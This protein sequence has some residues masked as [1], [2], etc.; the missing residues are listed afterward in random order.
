MSDPNPIPGLPNYRH[1]ALGD[2]LSTN[3]EG[4]DR[5]RSGEPGNLWVTG[6]RQLQGK[7]RR[8]RSW[9]S[10]KGN[11]YASLLLSGRFP[12]ARF[13]TLPLVA[14]LAVHDALSPFFAD[15]PV[16]PAIKWP[17]D[18]RVGGAKICGI[19]LESE[20]LPN[21]NMAVVIGCGINCAHFPDIDGYPA[22]SLEDCGVLIKPQDLFPYLAKAFDQVLTL[23]DRGNGF[24]TVRRR[25]LD[26]AEGVGKP[27]TVNLDNERISGTFDDIDEEG[28]L[29]LR[30]RDGHVE[31]ISAGD[32]FFRQSQ[33]PK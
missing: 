16:K 25:W 9:V 11:L 17:N 12:T 28:R 31:R 15:K 21:G 30:Q 10:E 14:G 22:T 2:T 27:V 26:G 29:L 6:E 20:L 19:L 13:G 3:L 24:E 1:L 32:L 23:W 8:G 5:A 18:I 33:E 4:L 7:G